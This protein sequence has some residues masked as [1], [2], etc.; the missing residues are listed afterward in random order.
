MQVLIQYV[1]IMSSPFRYLV[2][3]AL[4]VPK[5]VTITLEPGVSGMELH[6][7]YWTT[8]SLASWNRFVVKSDRANGARA[9]AA[10]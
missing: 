10:G 5:G 2:G 3:T 6:N 7:E 1:R 8:A 4:L 9:S